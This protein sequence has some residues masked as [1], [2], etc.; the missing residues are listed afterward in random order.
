MKQLFEN[1]R[2][3]VNES[4]VITE[5]SFDVAKERLEKKALTK[6]IKGMAFDEEMRVMTLTPEQIESA[7]DAL[8]KIVLEL[9][10]EDLTDGKPDAN[11]NPTK[12]QKGLTLEW[13]ISIGINDP[14][15]KPRF[16]N[17]AV[18][19]SADS[20]RSWAVATGAAAGDRSIL[21]INFH[22]RRRDLERYWHTH[23]YS[24]KKDIFSIKT[25]GELA[26][27]AEA[28][29]KE[30]DA[31]QED[32]DYLDA[33]K[34]IEVFRDDDKM[35]IY[36][37]HNKGA[38]C[39]YGKGTE[40]CTAAPGLNY[41]E[42][43]YEPD[44]PLF[45]FEIKHG[46]VAGYGEDTDRYQFHFGSNQFMDEDD[47]DIPDD[48]RDEL[49]R[50]LAKTDAVN[51]YDIVQ[52][53]VNR[54]EVAQIIYDEDA[55]PEMLFMIVKEYA[56]TG[57]DN[58]ILDMIIDSDNTTEEML[59]YIIINDDERIVEAM[60]DPRVSAEWLQTLADSDDMNH[61]WA[62]S[63]VGLTQ[64]RNDAVTPE[65]LTKLSED[66]NHSTQANVARNPLTPP[67]VLVK[68]AKSPDAFKGAYDPER[69]RV[70]MIRNP[71][72]PTE[73][74]PLLYKR[75]LAVVEPVDDSPER[76][77]LDKAAGFS[78]QDIGNLVRALDNA[79][80]NNQ[81]SPPEILRDIVNR[82]TRKY[83]LE[84]GT[85]YWV[86]RNPNT[87]ADVLQTL[88]KSKDPN[89]KRN[90]LDQLDNQYRGIAENFKRFLK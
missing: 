75:A 8:T 11:G 5:I 76:K 66:E 15:M 39:H 52:Y 82:T 61:R 49:I 31:A 78:T 58:D 88:S 56:G 50:A 86:A 47:E 46:A 30:F 40:W 35:R 12:P 18:S 60:R 10:P 4:P 41:F 25:W 70:E 63:D 64:H 29:K 28:A 37:L 85:L 21:P 22:T 9:V 20:T 16:Y 48:Y 79:V 67:E 33:D 59:R 19:N 2:N 27:A 32:K 54:N 68:M 17:E 36:A 72:L 87:P 24:Q 90:A 14:R 38:A 23:E 65:I 43:Y 26:V 74:I 84:W 89:I 53:W 81:N 34:G 69:E 83:G 3:H 45:Y 73:V 1:W 55:D 57:K 71:S 42:Q 51:K 13:I 80:A 62:L 7:K 44:D 77:A 6:W